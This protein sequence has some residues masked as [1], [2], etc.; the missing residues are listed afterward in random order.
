[1]VRVAG[2]VRGLVVIVALGCSA[3]CGTARLDILGEAMSPTLKDGEKVS[4]TRTVERLNRG[5]I[6][7][8]KYPK[9]E[10]KSFVKRVVG[11]PNERIE[12][13]AGKVSINGQFISEAYV[14]AENRSNDTWGPLD[15]PDGNYFM[16]GDNRRHSSD[17]RH[18]GTVGR[19]AI[20]A[21]VIDR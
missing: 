17:S 9:D 11:L 15:I 5:D 12:S 3:G 8:F 19:G 1:M 10:A 16:M 21:K 14:V 2:V 6:V 18:W 20:W 13:V 4:A 7:A